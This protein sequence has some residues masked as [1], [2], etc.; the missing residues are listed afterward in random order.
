MFESIPELTQQLTNPSN[1]F[2]IAGLLLTFTELFV[3]IEAGLDLV[4]IGSILVISG[5][6]G[7]LAGSIWVTIIAAI[8]LTILYFTYARKIVKQKIIFSTQTTNVDKLLGQTAIVTK[9]ITKHKPGQILLDN[10]HWRAESDQMIKL[11]QEVII[12]TVQGVTVQ[13]KP[14]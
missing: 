5:F 7:I 4:L 6:T 3:G 2:I 10:E 8:I 13:V 11:D 14:K 9:P 12:T 1:L